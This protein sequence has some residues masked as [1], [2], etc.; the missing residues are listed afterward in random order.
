MSKGSQTKISK[1]LNIGSY[2]I[3]ILEGCVTCNCFSGIAAV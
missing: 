2:P 1:V 3:L